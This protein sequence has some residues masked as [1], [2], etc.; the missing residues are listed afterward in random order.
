VKRAE[1]EVG[2]GKELD[3]S[4]WRFLSGFEWT[5]SSFDGRCGYHGWIF[6]ARVEGDR[7]ENG[8]KRRDKVVQVDVDRFSLP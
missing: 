1:Q 7:S 5:S 6:D 3:D 2:S 8:E 4:F